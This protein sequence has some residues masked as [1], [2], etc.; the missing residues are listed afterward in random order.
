MSYES[1]VRFLFNNFI[2]Y[3]LANI[4]IKILSI[5]KLDIKVLVLFA[6]FTKLID[7]PHYAFLRMQLLRPK[8]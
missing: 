6:Q 1:T 8:R 5:S 7:L 3:R 4:I 2:R